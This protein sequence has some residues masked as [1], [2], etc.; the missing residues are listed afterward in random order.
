MLCPLDLMYAFY[1]LMFSIPFLRHW[2]AK[3]KNSK[4]I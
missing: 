3:Y 4:K 1:G 2:I